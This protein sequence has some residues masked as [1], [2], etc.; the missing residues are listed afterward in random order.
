ML[1][2]L[3]LFFMGL[4]I[5]QFGVALFLE[6]NLGSDPFTIFTQGIAGLLGITPGAANRLLT[7]TIFLVIFMVDRKN[8]HIGTFLSILCV[9]VVLD[10][11]LVLIAPFELSTYPLL[12]KIIMFVGACII[13]GIG[14]PILKCGLLGVPPND[15]IY[16][17]VMDFWG[18]PYGKVRMMTDILFAIVGIAFGGVMGLGT[19]LCILLIGPIVQFFFPKIEKLSNAFLGE[20]VVELA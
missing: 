2:K 6:L 8:I 15:L 19:L 4:F 7:G 20:E 16:F 5:I 11:M 14:V 3:L 18:K 9:G 10:E 1:K 13:I 17:T 12:I